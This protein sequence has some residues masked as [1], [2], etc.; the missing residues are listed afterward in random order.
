MARSTNYITA[1]DFLFR[2]PEVE[3]IERT[4]DDGDGEP[5]TEVLTAIIEQACDEV[6]SFYA[7]RGVP[8][9]VDVVKEPLAKQAAIYLAIESLYTRRGQ[10]AE[11]TVHWQTIKSMRTL[12]QKV[13]EGKVTVNTLATP[14]ATTTTTEPALPG[15]GRVVSVNSEPSRTRT[16]KPGAIIS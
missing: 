9:P 5:D 15:D 13:A 1:D 3:R 10:T 6:D 11:N 16:R 8:V 14:A 2:L 12:L 4:D 7:I